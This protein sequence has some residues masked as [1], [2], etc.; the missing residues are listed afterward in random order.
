MEINKVIMIGYSGHAY[1]S[2]EN[3]LLNGYEVMG[4]CETEEKAENPYNLPFLGKEADYFNRTISQGAFIAIGS[5]R[6]REKI[7]SNFPYIRFV[8]LIHPNSTISST[9]EILVDG[10]IL[11]NAGVVVNALAKIGKGVI[12]NTACVVEHECVVH[13]F[14]HIAP[15]A[16]LAGNVTIGRRS[17]IG[18]N[19][20]VKQGVVIG[21]DVVVGA[22][23][24]VLQ[25]IP[26]GKVVAGIPSKEIKKKHI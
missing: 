26:D 9:A 16:V 1:V 21:N 18:A 8:N 10:N 20:V 11:L 6:L 22:G 14:A 23:S 24:V 15:G 25:D 13:E 5:N 19:A 2:I 3:A 7:M 17:F 12:L 4:Y